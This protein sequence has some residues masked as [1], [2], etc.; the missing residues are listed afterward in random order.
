MNHLQFLLVV[1]VSLVEL[2]W[3][4][5]WLVLLV[6]LVS[7]QNVVLAPGVVFILFFFA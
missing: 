4:S 2:S 7:G 3:L 1:F 5:P 6:E